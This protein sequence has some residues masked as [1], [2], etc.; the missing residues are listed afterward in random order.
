M[1]CEVGDVFARPAEGRSETGVVVEEAARGDARED[2]T[3]LGTVADGVALALQDAHEDW[4]GS[5]D[6][7]RLAARLELLLSLLRQ[8]P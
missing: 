2:R 8:R 3:T 6:A 7:I 4:C 5:G 1:T